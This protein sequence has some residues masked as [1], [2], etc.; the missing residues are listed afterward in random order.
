MPCPFDWCL[1]QFEVYPDVIV[2][3]GYEMYM[4]VGTMS[5]LALVEYGGLCD[6]RSPVSQ[7][8]Y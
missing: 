1:S 4:L 8:M 6:R 2:T 3:F 5:I 7:D